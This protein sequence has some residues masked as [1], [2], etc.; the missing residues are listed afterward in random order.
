MK[1][2]SIEAI[3]K[4][5]L[6]KKGLFFFTLSFLLIMMFFVSFQIQQEKEKYQAITSNLFKVLQISFQVGDEQMIRSQ[7][8]KILEGSDIYYFRSIN[9]L[10]SEVVE[11]RESFNH[12]ESREISFRNIFLKKYL[13]ISNDFDL[14]PTSNEKVRVVVSIKNTILR[15]AL[16]NSSMSAL[17]LNVFLFLILFYSLGRVTFNISKPFINAQ[18]EL[19]KRAKQN[20]HDFSPPFQALKDIINK[21]INTFQEKDK[22]VL[23]HAMKTMEKLTDNLLNLEDEKLLRKSGLISLEAP[24]LEAIQEVEIVYAKNENIKLN[25]VNE[26]RDIVLKANHHYLKRA[27]T[28]ILKNACQSGTDIKLI[29]VRLK[30]E[31]DFCF[32]YIEDRGKGMGDQI[33]EQIFE[34][35]FSTK[36]NEGHGLGLSQVKEYIESINGRIRFWSEKERGTIFEIKLPIILN[37]QTVHVDSRV[38][39]VVIEDTEFTTMLWKDWA[40]ELGLNLVFYKSFFS[41]KEEIERFPTSLP[42]VLDFSLNDGSHCFENLGFLKNRDFKKVM[43]CTTK[44]LRIPDEYSS[45][46]VSGKRFPKNFFIQKVDHE[47]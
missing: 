47:S 15:S 7:V 24:L 28:N 20:A 14:Y 26:G 46:L 16:F 3:L 32:I 22:K 36:E 11:E 33:S 8:R 5:E 39:G 2:N 37:K 31:E 25:F 9:D 23:T 44:E 1:N 45:Y 29:E 30:Q 19:V 6:L 10:G 4:K 41:F 34:N 35:N 21:E 43:V 13:E 40:D 27:I 12:R 38:D 42:I 17:T 18:E